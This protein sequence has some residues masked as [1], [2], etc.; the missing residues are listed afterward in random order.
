VSE[1]LVTSPVPRKKWESLMANDLGALPEQAPEWIDALVA[2]SRHRDASRLY[3]F[4]DGSEVLLPLVERRG[5]A[6]VGGLLESYP[7]GW[8]MGGLIGAEADSSMTRAILQDLRSLGQ[9]RIAIR[10]DPRRWAAWAD[11]VDER[12][13]CIPRRAHVVDLTGGEDAVWARMSKSARRGVRNAERLGVHIESGRSDALLRKYYSMFLLSVDRWAN[14]QHEPRALAHARARYRDPLAKLQ[15]MSEHLGDN[16]IV[17]LA[18]IDGKPA[19]GSITLLAGTAHDTRSAMDR[20]LVGSSGAGDLVQWTTLKL[21]CE[22]GCSA[23]HLGESGQSANLSLFKEKFGAR[24]YDY[25]ELRIDRLPWTRADLALRSAV[26][27]V[28]GFR[29]V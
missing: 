29:D 1:P 3:S 7:H 18:Y 16:L 17:T 15:S 2:T 26:K 28:L 19:T 9:Q 25:A 23:Y 20:E 22:R 8:G 21:A 24:P 6:G 13:F 27:R 10:P 14:H 5:M 4:A 11:A 12:V